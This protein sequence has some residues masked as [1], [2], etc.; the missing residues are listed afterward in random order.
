[1]IEK[2]SIS[3]RSRRK[4][5]N[6]SN[7]EKKSMRISSNLTLFLNSI[8]KHEKFTNEIENYP[9]H[10]SLNQISKKLYPDM[11]TKWY[12]LE[13]KL[14]WIIPTII[15]EKYKHHFEMMRR[16]P[17]VKSL[18]VPLN[19]SILD[20]IL[21]VEKNEKK[22]KEMNKKVNEMYEEYRKQNNKNREK[23]L[24]NFYQ[25]L[26]GYFYP[27][28]YVLYFSYEE[29]FQSMRELVLEKKIK[30]H[31]TLHFI[32]QQILKKYRELNI[33]CDFRM[34]DI[35]ADNILITKTN[36]VIFTNFSYSECLN[37][38]LPNFEKMFWI[39]KSHFYFTNTLNIR[40]NK[41]IMNL[42]SKNSIDQIKKEN[43]DIIRIL[44]MYN[45]MERILFYDNH[46]IHLSKNEIQYINN[47]KIEWNNKI[48]LLEKEFESI[49]SFLNRKK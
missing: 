40:W 36:K 46:K 6:T 7:D 24:D 12:I 49:F 38:Y 31:A 32:F 34:Y 8:Q 26:K 15:P 43:I 29:P 22:K 10:S 19:P 11:D 18:L 44:R 30:Q 4:E 25:L 17:K 23:S 14:A 27:K 41:S 13:N 5:N 1:M 39:A 42:F 35:Q 2:N 3:E 21:D 37:L 9:G 45:T 20:S 48:E 28:K 16:L 47:K 33:E